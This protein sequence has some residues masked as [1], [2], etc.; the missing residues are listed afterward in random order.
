MQAIMFCKKSGIFCDCEMR[1]FVRPG[2]PLR[3]HDDLDLIAAKWNALEVAALLGD[4][5]KR[6]WARDFGY[7]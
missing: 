4:Q 2:L 6:F 3:E 7:P 1:F 5:P